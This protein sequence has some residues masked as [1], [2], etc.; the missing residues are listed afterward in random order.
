M[1]KLLALF[2]A[3]MMV[4]SLAACSD[5][6]SNPSAPNSDAGTQESTPAGGEE[7][8][9]PADGDTTGGVDLSAYPA[10]LNDWTG[11]NFID[12]FTA[13]GVFAEGPGRESWLQDHVDYWPET[14]VSECAGY[15][16]DDGLILIM[17]FTFDG[18]LPDT[19]PEAASEMKNYIKENQALPEDY[20]GMPI[21]H[22]VGDVAFCYMLTTDDD[23]YNAMDAAYN[24]LVSAMGVTPDF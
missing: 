8:Q 18:S 3:M 1:K 17:I 10:D 23:V 20:M 5:S 15:W 14:P 11:Q 19:T 21:D 12:Y 4:L 24:D 13:A 7:S 22:L 6:G 9:G 2:L 16:D